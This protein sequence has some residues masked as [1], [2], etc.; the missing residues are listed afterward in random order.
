MMKIDSDEEI[1]NLH[2]AYVSEMSTKFANAM[3]KDQLYKRATAFMTD[4]MVWM[5]KVLKIYMVDTVLHYNHKDFLAALEED[6]PPML[7]EVGIWIIEVAMMREKELGNKDRMKKYRTC[8]DIIKKI[9]DDKGNFSIEYFQKEG[10][11]HLNNKYSPKKCPELAKSR[12]EVK[13]PYS[14]KNYARPE[15][16]QHLQKVEDDAAADAKRINSLK[17]SHCGCPEGSSKHKLCSA[18]KQRY[19]CSVECQKQ[20]WKT[21][22]KAECKKL[23]KAK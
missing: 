4:G 20:D 16:F 3:R 19:Y 23:I 15:Y 6:I 10:K 5:M 12:L 22:H 18:C 21:K 13:F 11:Y 7:S 2:D 8:L 17:C 14:Y 9:V 1:I